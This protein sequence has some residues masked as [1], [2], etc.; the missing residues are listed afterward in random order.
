MKN[1]VVVDI[2]GTVAGRE[3]YLQEFLQFHAKNQI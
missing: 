2:D 1:I 3:E